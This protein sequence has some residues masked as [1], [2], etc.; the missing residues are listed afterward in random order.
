MRF[1]ETIFTD[2]VNHFMA[3]L[4]WKS[5]NKVL[6]NIDL[7]EQTN[8]PR[9]IKKLKN[10]IWEM[11]TNYSGNQLRLLAF[12]DKTD[13]ERTLVI[14]ALGFIKKTKKVP[15]SEI[16]HALQIRNQYFKNKR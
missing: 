13:H 7:A 12:W 15:Q 5:A 9:L 10:D 16:N 6:Y 14:A 1:F 8:D 4:D 2:E 11:R 3:K